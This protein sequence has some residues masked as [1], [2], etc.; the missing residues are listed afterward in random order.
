MR[1]RL[2]HRAGPFLAV[3]VPLLGIGLADGS[4]A[5]DSPWLYGIQW[6]GPTTNLSD[7]STMT[8]GKAIWD[9][10]TVMTNDGEGYWGP[11]GQLAKCQAIVAQGH[12]LIIRVQPIWGKAFPWPE[13]TTPSMAQFLNQVTQLATLYRDVCHVWVLGNEMNLYMEWAGR[14]LMPETYIDA[15]AQFSDR[16]KAVTSSL[17]PQTVLVGPAAVGVPDTYHFM[18]NTEYLSRMCDRISAAG[19]HTTCPV[20]R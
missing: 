20:F 12:T 19:Y 13:D 17:G 5:A 2:D 7:V 18:S 16:I 10:E 9:V 3:F 14:E 1:T 6:V 8:G 11:G 4:L 15:A